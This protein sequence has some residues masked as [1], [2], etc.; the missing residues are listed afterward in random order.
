MS[1]LKTDER[2]ALIEYGLCAMA[3]GIHKGDFRVEWETYCL[4]LLGRKRYQKSRLKCVQ[5]FSSAINDRINYAIDDKRDVI[6]EIKELIR[7]LEESLVNCKEY[8]PEWGYVK[9]M[10][11]KMEEEM[12]ILK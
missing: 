12:E 7:N 4:R 10:I 9:C 8:D 2:K 1:L 3:A 5:E 6:Y 11:R